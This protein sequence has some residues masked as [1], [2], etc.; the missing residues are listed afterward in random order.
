MWRAMKRAFVTS[1]LAA[2]VIVVTAG[3]AWAHEEINPKSFPTG[4]PTFF[5]LSAADEQKV[6]LVKVVLTAPSGVPL[7]AT[8]KEPSG[9]AESL[10]Q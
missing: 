2:T 8:T 5:T 9:W 10:I 4:T 6:D 1:V 7:G 3:S